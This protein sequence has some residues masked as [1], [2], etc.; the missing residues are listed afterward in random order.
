MIPADEFVMVSLASA[1]HD[2]DH[3]PDADRLDITRPRTG[4]LAFG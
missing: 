1:N 3:F 2:R 4:H